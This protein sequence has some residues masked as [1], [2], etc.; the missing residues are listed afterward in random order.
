MTW[1]AL[2]LACGPTDTPG[3]TGPVDT[4][5]TSTTPAEPTVTLSEDVQP[6]IDQ[7][8]TEICHQATSINTFS[9]EPGDTYDEVV[10]V[11]AV[12]VPLLDRVEPGEPE[13]SYLMHKLWGTHTEVGGMGMSMPRDS[14]IPHDARAVF[15]DWIAQGAHP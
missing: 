5:P 14:E 4:A 1:L 6:L 13:L 9:M 12:Q 8:C 10:D 3:E 7:Y 11:P 15:E 2:L